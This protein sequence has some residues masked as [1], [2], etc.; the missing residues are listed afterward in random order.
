MQDSRPKASLT[1][2][3][4][5]RVNRSQQTPLEQR[6]LLLKQDYKKLR[7]EAWK[8]REENIVFESE[9]AEHVLQAQRSTNA[10]IAA[11]NDITKLEDRLKTAE[12]ARELVYKI[13]TSLLYEAGSLSE[14]WHDRHL[15]ETD[16]PLGM[17]K[18]GVEYEE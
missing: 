18:F 3:R 4:R 8:L 12:E 5:V 2:M 6:Y 16:N 15:D 17:E 10:R 7:D 14:E 13:Y 11:Q 1:E 9:Q